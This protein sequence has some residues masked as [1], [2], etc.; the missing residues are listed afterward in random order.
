MRQSVLPSARAV[1]I[2]TA[3][4]LAVIGTVCLYALWPRQPTY[5]GRPLGWW[6]ECRQT[7]HVNAMP[8]EEEEA[9]VGIRQIGTNAFP[10][11]LAMLRVR[12]SRFKQIVM[13]WS[14]KQ[15]IFKFPF[16]PAD[17]RRAQAFG[18]YE[19]LGTAA[20]GQI[21][22]LSEILTNDRLPAV[23]A[24]AAGV[25]GFI[26]RDDGDRAAPALFRAT[27]DKDE[28]VRNNSFWALTQVHPNPETTIPILIGG[29]DD[30]CAT[31]RE[32][33]AAALGYNYGSQAKAAVP[34]LLRTLTI[35]R[36]ASS[37]LSK[38]DP[39]AAAKAG[40]K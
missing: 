25:L 11:L 7:A 17:R 31:A 19:A 8:L 30:S 14:A 9:K 33:A 2:S 22:A 6:L 26:A 36:A 39:E 12:D 38:I 21:P 23:R 32:N 24:L 18:G 34:A 37:A 27:K 16:I 4:A 29:L 20:S 40:V 3:L 10:A 15:S 1:I 13:A 35:N 28:T 5:R